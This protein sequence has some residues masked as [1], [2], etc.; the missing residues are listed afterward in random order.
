MTFFLPFHA[1]AR[2]LETTIFWVVFDLKKWD[3]IFKN[4]PSKICGRQPQKKLQGYGLLFPN[5]TQWFTL[6]AAL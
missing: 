1:V 4:W 5:A 2:S 3:K 6:Q